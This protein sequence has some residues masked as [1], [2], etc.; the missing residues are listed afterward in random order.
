MERLGQVRK[1]RN[2]IVVSRGDEAVLLPVA[3]GVDPLNVPLAATWTDG[4]F[5]TA[6]ERAHSNGSKLRKLGLPDGVAGYA[7]YRNVI[8]QPTVG[9]STW[10]SE[11][12]QIA[13]RSSYEAEAV[14]A[15]L[16]L[17]DLLGRLEDDRQLPAA[18]QF[19]VLLFSDCQSLIAALKAPAQPEEAAASELARLREV[20]GL[21]AGFQPRWEARRRIKRRLGH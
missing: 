4:G 15:R 18:D 20:I 1:K 8:F 21:F 17:E 2:L 3:P 14:A 10:Q 11:P 7:S 12:T 5:Y 13:G 16:G 6:R 19:Q 9:H